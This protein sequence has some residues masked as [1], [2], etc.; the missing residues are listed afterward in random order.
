V[1]FEVSSLLFVYLLFSRKL[2]LA[3]QETKVLEAY[4]ESHKA[5]DD[6]KSNKSDISLDSPSSMR[7]QPIKQQS[8]WVKGHGRNRS[9]SDG[10]VLLQPGHSLAPHHPAWSLSALLDLFGPLIFPVHRAALLRRRI[11]ISG[12]A[13]VHQ[14][15][16]FGRLTLPVT[17][18]AL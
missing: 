8:G 7:F 5:D 10:T 17:Q 6:R 9:A 4:W 2:V 16:D 14:T 11:L 15:C 12:H 3:P 1:S 13:P 18:I